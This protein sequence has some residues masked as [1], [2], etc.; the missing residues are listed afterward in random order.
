M[1]PGFSLT[2]THSCL[3]S[4]CRALLDP[5]RR[6]L[7]ILTVP[8]LYSVWTVSTALPC[9]SLLSLCSFWPWG[10]IISFL[11]SQVSWFVVFFWSNLPLNSLENFSSQELF[12]TGANSFAFFYFTFLKHL[13][14][15][16]A[17]W[18]S[19]SV[20]ETLIVC[21][22]DLLSKT[23]ILPSSNFYQTFCYSLLSHWSF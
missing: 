20:T 6:F 10:Q 8:F 23:S 22:W 17:H 7:H 11:L 2:S 18:E 14:V 16:L 15:V 9:C 21:F 4:K 1:L 12:I 19:Q 13:P 5:D 3:S